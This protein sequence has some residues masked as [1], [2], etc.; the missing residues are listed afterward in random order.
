M[1]AARLTRPRRGASLAEVRDYRIALA[2][3]LDRI[4]VPHGGEF[5]IARPGV[6]ERP[7]AR[8]SDPGTSRAAARDVAPRVA[9]QHGRIVLAIAQHGHGT[10]PGLTHGEVRDLARVAQASVGP[11][12]A[13]LKRAGYLAEVGERVA[14]LGSAQAVLALTEQGRKCAEALAAE[15]RRRGDA[16][17]AE[18]TALFEVPRA[19]PGHYGNEYA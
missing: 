3:A 7:R 18:T 9:N 15:A 10:P 14:D 2:R 17:G 11:R 5:V 8:S 19:T 6:D 13:E 1:S 16:S 12:L 4:G